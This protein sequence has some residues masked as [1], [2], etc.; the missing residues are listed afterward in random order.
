MTLASHLEALISLLF[1]FFIIFPYSALTIQ[2]QQ[3][4]SETQPQL[5]DSDLKSRK[6]R[7]M[8]S[9]KV[10]KLC[11]GTETV[12]SLIAKDPELAPG[13]AWKQ[14]YGEHAAGHKESV[15]TARD[16]RDAH[17]AE[18]LKRARECGKWGPTEP[19]ELFL[20]V[21]HNLTFA[22]FNADGRV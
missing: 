13:A 6:H 21:C 4:H 22:P 1:Q 19:S 14:L 2:R 20:K 11:N 5:E 7:A 9:D 3:L 12:S 18:D 8:I 15:A 10:Y 16:H 17:T